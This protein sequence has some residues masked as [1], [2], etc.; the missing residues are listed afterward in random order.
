MNE[1]LLGK[2]RVCG[3]EVSRRAKECPDCR[4]P[5]PTMTEEEY[6]KTTI[7][8]YKKIMD[9]LNTSVW[10]QILYSIFIL[11]SVYSI[12]ILVILVITLFSNC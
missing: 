1:D 12:V 5:R 2:C 9:W 10:G 11:F 3:R 4:E 6:Q 8:I 7:Y